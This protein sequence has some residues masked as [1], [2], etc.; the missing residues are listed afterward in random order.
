[1]CHLLDTKHGAMSFA[2]HNPLCF[3]IC[4]T[5]KMVLCIYWTENMVICHLPDT[6]HGDVS[7][8]LH[9]H[10]NMS[11]AGH[12]HCDVSFAGYENVYFVEHKT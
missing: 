7:F 3:V 12:K 2:V 6:K 8:A 4:R 9:K 5:Q 11:F 10:G 1:M